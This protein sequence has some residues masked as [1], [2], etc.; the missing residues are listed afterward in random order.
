M[1]VSRV[2]Q[3]G[4][5]G[6]L[7]DHQLV[8]II[9]PPRLDPIRQVLRTRWIPVSIRTETAPGTWAPLALALADMVQALAPGRQVATAAALP[10]P[11]MIK[12]EQRSRDLWIS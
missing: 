6:L 7:E 12:L 9:H 8:T 2:S 10:V 3:E 4:W 5:V 1:M 11:A